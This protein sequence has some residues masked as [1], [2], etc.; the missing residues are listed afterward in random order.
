MARNREITFYSS[1][2]PTGLC[3]TLWELCLG[4]SDKGKDKALFRVADHSLGLRR[5]G[6]PC[7]GSWSLQGTTRNACSAQCGRGEQSPSWC[8]SYA[9][10]RR[11]WPKEEKPLFVLGCCQFTPKP[12]NVGR[13]QYLTPGCEP[14]PLGV[15][16]PCTS[17]R[18]EVEHKARGWGN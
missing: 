2:R 13:P 6:H 14:L 8:I 5:G 3:V 10:H 1:P 18:C 15:R 7:R 12:M 9:D 4:R 16:H 17:H 11:P